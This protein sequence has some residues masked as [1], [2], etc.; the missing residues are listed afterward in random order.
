[1]KYQLKNIVVSITVEE[2]I[3]NYHDVEKFIIYC[4]QCDRYNACW[5][6]PPFDFDVTSRLLK[7]E[8]AHIFGTKIILDDIL[9]NECSDVQQCKETAYQII[10]EVRRELDGKLLA[11]ERQYPN[12]FAFFAGN[13]HLCEQG[14]CTRILKKPCLNPDRTRPSLEAFGF[15]ISKT[16]SQL[17]NTDLKWGGQERLPEYLVLVSGLFTNHKIGYNRK[18]AHFS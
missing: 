5:T 18:I 4:K 14:K 9:L 10:R 8:N 3:H 2:Y 16:S 17:L 7:Y 6:C 13:C 15:D 1:M 12:S 11:L